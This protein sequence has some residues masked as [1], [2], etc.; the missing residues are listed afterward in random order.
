MLTGA[1][2]VLRMVITKMLPN[3]VSQYLI[4]SL[5]KNNSHHGNFQVSGG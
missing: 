3:G 5:N 4:K 2:H 1:T